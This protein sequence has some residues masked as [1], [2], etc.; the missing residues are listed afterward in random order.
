[1]YHGPL[2]KQAR[3][4]LAVLRDSNDG[5]AI[6]QRDLELRGPGEVL[7]TRQTGMLQ[8]RIADLGRDRS[9]FPA[10]E[11]VAGALLAHHPQRVMPLVNRWIGNGLNYETV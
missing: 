9:L 3:A 6:A 8:F 2:T 10:V 1:M 7:G 4:R 5:F 11:K